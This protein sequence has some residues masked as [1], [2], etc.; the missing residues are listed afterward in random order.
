[1]RIS[2]CGAAARC[3]AFLCCCR[4]RKRELKLFAAS[5]CWE[6]CVTSQNLFFE[7][8]LQF[9]FQLKEEHPGR[10]VF[11]VI[12]LQLPDKSRNRFVTFQ[13][14]TREN[15]PVH[16][17][18]MNAGALLSEISKQIRQSLCE[19]TPPVIGFTLH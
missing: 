13:D 2:F 3:S 6:W 16:L 11:A 19:W 14:M 7:S 18:R 17:Q 5:L 1:M 15:L 10:L 9:H 12:R 4:L 8:H